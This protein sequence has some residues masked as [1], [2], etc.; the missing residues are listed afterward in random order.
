MQ[1]ITLKDLKRVSMLGA[2]AFGQ[3]LLVKAGTKYFALK[4]L[5]KEQIIKMGLQV[6]CGSAVQHYRNQPSAARLSCGIHTRQPLCCKALKPRS[7]GCV[8]TTAPAC[9]SIQPLQGTHQALAS[10]CG[11]SGDACS[12]HTAHVAHAD[13]HSQG[14][15]E[16]LRSAQ[17]ASAGCRSM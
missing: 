15:H 17:T 8:G 10:A 14:R 13:M 16:A 11:A 7:G 5:N 3:V 1:G 6:C 4:C 2:G 12:T 9:C